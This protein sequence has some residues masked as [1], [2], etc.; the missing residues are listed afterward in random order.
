MSRV[1]A[2]PPDALVLGGGGVLG[3]AWLSATL[4]G[5]RAG[6]GFDARDCNR[7]LG[8]SAGS[9]VAASLA[10]G[11]D[12][13]GRLGLSGLSTSVHDSAL[14]AARSRGALADALTA[15]AGLTATAAAP[16]ASLALGASGPGGALLRR[17]MLRRMP[18]GERSLGMLAE[19]VERSGVSFDGRLLVATVDLRSGRRVI[20]GDRDAPE[21]S[22]AQAVLASCA[23][24]GVFAPVEIGERSY[25]D[26]GAWS[27]TNMD[28]LRITRRERVLCLNPTGS[29]KAGDGPLAGAVGGVSRTLSASEALA[30]RHRGAS[31]TVVNPDGPSAAAMGADLMNPD[32][33]DAVVTAGYG[34]GLALAA[35][36]GA[37]A[38]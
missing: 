7:F 26:G 17:A 25:V 18:R 37:R 28:A 13:A 20:F 38:A 31:V 10:A 35:H 3:E 21:A 22:V 33:R 11:M 1:T 16:F 24:P 6:G 5:I 30:L 32:R 2:E 23:I 19:L 4:A 14:R 36:A 8:T 27:P 12:P 9:I 15:A 34:Q 29:L